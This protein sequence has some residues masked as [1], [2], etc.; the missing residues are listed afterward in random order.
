M[1]ARIKVGPPASALLK[2][3][4]EESGSLCTIKTWNSGQYFIPAVG[5]LSS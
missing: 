4:R 5:T 2:Q 3:L 1:H